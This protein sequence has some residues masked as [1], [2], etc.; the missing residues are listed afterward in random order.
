MKNINELNPIES[1]NQ[2]FLTVTESPHGMSCVQ[3]ENPSP[4]LRRIVHMIMTDNRID[5]EANKL[6]KKS[7]AFL[8]NNQ[9][10]YLLIEF[11]KEDY[12]EFV[13]Y[14]NQQINLDK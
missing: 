3:V 7:G 11:W 2:F 13:D 14:L 9:K 10:D 4:E 1:N 6:T 12:R 8:Q 5:S